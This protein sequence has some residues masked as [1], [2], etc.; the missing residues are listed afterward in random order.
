MC[1]SSMNI[2]ETLRSDS[3]LTIPKYYG[4]PKAILDT[5]HVLND[6]TAGLRHPKP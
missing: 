3:Q 6:I 4:F 2:Q 5:E 1:L